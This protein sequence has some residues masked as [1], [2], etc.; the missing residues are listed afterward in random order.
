MR[1][2]L[3]PILLTMAVAAGCRGPCPWAC[4]TTTGSPLP[5]CEPPTGGTGL[6][7]GETPA[8][9]RV[10]PSPCPAPPCPAPPQRVVIEVVQKSERPAPCPSSA[11]CPGACPNE[12]PAN[13]HARPAAPPMQCGA[14]PQQQF[15]MQP[16]PQAQYMMQPMQT[17]MLAGGPTLIPVQGAAA[18]AALPAANPP[19]A[20]SPAFGL[21]LD[22]LRLPL[23]FLRP[24]VIPGEPTAG[25]APQMML[26][27][28]PQQALMQ[29]PMMMAMPPTMPQQAMYAPQATYAAPAYPMQAFA[30]PAA[31]P[32]AQLAMPSVPVQ[33]SPCVTD[34]ELRA[35]EGAMA[36]REAAV[37]GQ[38]DAMTDEM[39]RQRAAIEA[40]QP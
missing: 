39:R 9:P 16:A 15:M 34:A 13:P 10:G 28:Q 35:R 11:P 12:Q 22:F 27:Q 19:S 38:V 14:V 20:S 1:V 2:V 31:Q 8:A 26:V 4:H 21:R 18:Y 23:P 29:Q 3:L 7:N 33:L 5:A 24:V 6:P 32:A 40:R 37:K 30:Q 36:A 25:P 17:P